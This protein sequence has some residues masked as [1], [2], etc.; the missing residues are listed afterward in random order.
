MI[1]AFTVINVF[2]L[3]E[4]CKSALRLLEYHL[5]HINLTLPVLLERLISNI[6][7]LSPHVG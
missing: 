3:M 7:L 1:R 2:R 6:D 4:M 5:Q